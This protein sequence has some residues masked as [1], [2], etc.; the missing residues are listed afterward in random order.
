MAYLGAKDKADARVKFAEFF[1]NKDRLPM[2]D[3]NLASG[4]D[5]VCGRCNSKMGLTAFVAGGCATCSDQLISSMMFFYRICFN[6]LGYSI[7]LQCCAL[8]SGLLVCSVV[9]CRAM[10]CCVMLYHAIHAP[11][12]WHVQLCYSMC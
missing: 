11:L 1:K 9:P 7:C 3:R 6:M 8:G 10:L 2:H 4:L 12:C 5:C